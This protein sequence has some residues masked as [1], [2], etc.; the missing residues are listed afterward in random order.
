MGGRGV[1]GAGGDMPSS[2]L[3]MHGGH[4]LSEQ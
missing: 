2:R 1:D 3:S 4:V